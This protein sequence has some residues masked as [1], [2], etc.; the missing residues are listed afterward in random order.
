MTVGQACRILELTEAI[1]SSKEAIKKQYRTLAMKHHPDKGG[2]AN[3]FKQVKEAYDVL[4]KDEAG[5]QAYIQQEV[6]GPGI[7]DKFVDFVT[8]SGSEDGVFNRYQKRTSPLY[9]VTQYCKQ[10]EVMVS[11]TMQAETFVITHI[12]D[13]PLP[14]PIQLGKTVNEAKLAIDKLALEQKNHR[15]KF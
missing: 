14:V 1:G 15:S 12:K 6:K 11:V 13:V 7:G 10:L 4:I 5:V 9:E 3:K 2:D 8:G